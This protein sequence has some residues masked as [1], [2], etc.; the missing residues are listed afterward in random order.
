MSNKGRPSQRQAEEPPAPE[1]RTRILTL[2]PQKGPKLT[3]EVQPD[4]EVNFHPYGIVVITHRGT[5]QEHARVYPWQ[6][7]AHVEVTVG[8]IVAPPTP[9]IV[10]VAEII[11][12]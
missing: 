12:P 1:P 11:K 6:H 3:L 4:G 7:Y 9:L 5:P 8:D 2:H 10:P